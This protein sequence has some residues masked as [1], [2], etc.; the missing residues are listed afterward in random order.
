MDS[1]VQGLHSAAQHLRV[2]SQLGHIPATKQKGCRLEKCNVM[3]KRCYYVGCE[4]NLTASPASR[5][6]LA[7]PPEATRDRPTSTSLL[8]KS[9][10]PFLSETL[11]SAAG[12]DKEESD[13]FH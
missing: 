6:V 13:H 3:I 8:A 1:R 10:S 5:R 9:T 12:T 4:V 7:V 2:S 11:K